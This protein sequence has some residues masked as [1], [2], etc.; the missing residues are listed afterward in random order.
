MQLEREERPLPTLEINP[1][2]KNLADLE[3]WVS[4]EDDFQ[5]QG[6]DPHPAIKMEIAV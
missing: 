3:K 1:E 6:Y 5:I 4:I 2:L